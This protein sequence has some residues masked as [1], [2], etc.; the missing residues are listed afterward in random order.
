MCVQIGGREIVVRVVVVVISACDE[1]AANGVGIDGYH[2]AIR[3]PPF[4]D[5]LLEGYVILIDVVGVGI[6]I[7][8]YGAGVNGVSTAGD[9]AGGCRSE[10]GAN[11]EQPCDAQE[12]YGSKVQGGC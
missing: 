2:A 11:G 10:A 7:I 4:V 8:Q 6:P 12:A 1:G 9:R 3:D 5:F